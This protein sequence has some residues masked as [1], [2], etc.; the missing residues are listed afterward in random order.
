MIP[1]A[2][3]TLISTVVTNVFSS[4]VWETLK[5]EDFEDSI[6][7][8]FENSEKLFK[9]K[10]SEIDFYNSFIVRECNLQAVISWIK[11]EN[12]EAS[13]PEINSDNFDGTK[14]LIEQVDYFVQ[15]LKHVIKKDPVLSKYTTE[16]V[17]RDIF[18]L[19]KENND[20]LTSQV[21][22]NILI[23]SL[24]ALI[25]TG[26]FISV[27]NC[28]KGLDGVV[29][30]KS[31]ISLFKTKLC[32]FKD[33]VKDAEPIHSML[34]KKVEEAIVDDSIAFMFM[35]DFNK[36]DIERAMQF[37]K[38]NTLQEVFQLE[39]NYFDIGNAN[40]L[41]TYTLKDNLSNETIYLNLALKQIDSINISNICELMEKS[42]SLEYN[43]INDFKLN[44][45]I[46]SEKINIM[47][48]FFQEPSKE[49]LVEQLHYCEKLEEKFKYCCKEISI[50]FYRFYIWI[51]SLIS[52]EKYQLNKSGMPN[53]L[54]DEPTIVEID[55]SCRIETQKDIPQ[56]QEINSLCNKLSSNA[57]WHQL[58]Y[59]KTS[60]ERLSALE[61][62][63]F[64]VKTD[65]HIFSLYYND[66][67][68]IYGKENADKLVTIYQD[69]DNISDVLLL[70]QSQSDPTSNNIGK[71]KEMLQ[72]RTCSFEFTRKLMALLSEHGDIDFVI[73]FLREETTSSKTFY[74]DFAQYL[75]ITQATEN[76]K[77]AQ[78]IVISL[79]ADG[80]SSGALLELYATI[81]G[82]LGKRNHALSVFEQAYAAGNKKT[83]I[84]AQILQ[85]RCLLNKCIDD[86][87]LKDGTT[88]FIAEI[89]YLVYISYIKLSNENNS[90]PYLKRALLLC[91]NYDA[92]IYNTFFSYTIMHKSEVP[93]CKSIDENMAVCLQSE[94]KEMFVMI[95][96][97]SLLTTENG[98][99]FGH[100]K[101]I[102]SKD[103]WFTNE[104]FHR[105][106]GET[107]TWL[108]EKFIVK[109][110]DNSDVTL[111]HLC[112]EALLQNGMVKSFQVD[113]DDPIKTRKEIFDILDLHSHDTDSLVKM[114]T[115]PVDMPP[116][117][118]YML[119]E[120]LGKKYIETVCALM[121]D[122]SKRIW[123]SENK[124]NSIT[125]H[126]YVL[127]YNS[128][129]LLKSLQLDN[130]IKQSVAKFYVAK[131]TV[132]VISEEYEQLKRTISSDN[133]KTLLASDGDIGIVEDSDEVK[134]KNLS[135]ITGVKQFSE[136]L[137]A[138]SSNTDIAL[139]RKEINMAEVIGSFDYDSFVVAKEN[140]Y[141]LVTD[142]VFLSICCGM[143]F[144]DI[145]F[146]SVDKVMQE[147]DLSAE[148]LLDCFLILKNSYYFSA[149]SFSSIF[150]LSEKIT[151]SSEEDFESIQK[152]IDEFLS[153]D[154]TKELGKEFG[155]W[156]IDIYKQILNSENEWSVY[157]VNT[158]Q[159]FTIV[160]FS[161]L[162]PEKAQ[163]IFSEDNI[164]KMIKQSIEKLFI[165]NPDAD[166]LEL[167]E[168]NVIE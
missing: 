92:N 95:H 16:T 123:Y 31:L 138:L 111:S 15:C 28:I 91:K 164:R 38:N 117:S 66:V 67:K 136:S 165:T 40:G 70:I 98:Y 55:F 51:S 77:E 6:L 22:Q 18:Q 126:K 93:S 8:A 30:L 145:N 68:E 108:D 29:Q 76:V 72:A 84:V 65:S 154:E 113:V 133:I 60:A 41:A 121:N 168:T 158:L 57:L 112:M 26:D 147:L 13:K 5:K 155:Q 7:S 143:E 9:Q 160:A 36:C 134:R 157:F 34:M 59:N 139:E 103:E 163:E 151:I 156:I 80:Y 62:Y 1:A 39:D 79:F 104:L 100:Y 42:N 47:S 135:F 81:L 44:H 20:I 137:I 4:F 105:Q 150:D 124:N 132:N 96:D 115:D 125:T 119:S 23:N 141:I 102:N 37:C 120:K 64:L 53:W 114:Y 146:C 32:Y 43:F 148:K 61:E 49:L 116:I 58:L 10:Y 25:N 52:Y 166:S 54:I 88:R 75:Y 118:F 128:L 107:I 35:A 45:R 129:I 63:K 101:H 144:V 130:I 24:N 3:V 162:Y 109:S 71:I 159:K 83:P 12:I 99:C 69:V 74:F 127:T 82:F 97:D 89:Q 11:N 78:K 33:F 48:S 90:F 21:N 2:I 17:T 167:Q 27:E 122:S 73:D 94:D 50:P 14:A 86:V 153:F 110:I 152:K 46:F 56:L 85:D 149:I 161:K 106:I 87:I 131:A 140:N 19:A 142:D